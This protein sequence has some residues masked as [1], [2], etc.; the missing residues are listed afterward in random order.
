MEDSDE[1]RYTY[2]FRKMSTSIDK[3][4]LLHM[5]TCSL[6]ALDSVRQI[7]LDWDI[8]QDVLIFRN[9]FVITPP[10]STNITEKN[11]SS[12]DLFN[13]MH[14]QDKELFL[15]QL[16]QA[17]KGVDDSEFSL[18]RMELRLKDSTIGWR[19]IDISGRIVE[20]D[21]QGR[22]IRMLGYLSDINSRKQAEHKLVESDSIKREIL[23]NAL[24]CIITVNHEGAIINFNHASEKTFGYTCASILGKKFTDVVMTPAWRNEHHLELAYFFQHSEHPI[25]HR[26]VELNMMRANGTIFPVET[27]IVPIRI[28]DHPIFTCFIRDISELML[29]QAAL[30]D[31]ATRYR[32]LVEL[33]P[34][35]IFVCR[36][37]RLALTNHAA[38]QLLRA[39]HAH[40]LTDI[41]ILDFI[42]PDH[43]A[44]FLAH[45]HKLQASIPAT[46]FLE[47]QWIRQNG[48]PFFAEV[49]ATS[50]HY[51]GQLAIQ[52][53]VRDITIRKSA[54]ALQLGQN[55][56][57]NMIATGV[58][59]F[60]ILRA[61]AQFIDSQS[62][63][64]S[65]AILL[66]DC[67]GATLSNCVS[68]SLPAAYTQ[69]VNGLLV[70][71]ASGS[72][73]TAIFRAEPVVVTNIETDP[74]WSTCREIA[75]KHGL[76]A[77]SSWPIFGKNKKILG[78][79]ALYFH[80]TMAPS[81]N[82]SNLM[83]IC[84]NLAGI[85][86]DSR[87]SE[88][89]IR[90]LAHYDGLTS[91]PNRF[92]FKEYLDLALH[93]AHR[94][95]FKFAVFFLDLD[96][97]KDINDT[98]GHEAGDD[99]LRETARRLRKCLRQ[100]DKI[101]RIGGDEFYIL[102]E[103]LDH[104]HYAAEVAQKLLD[105]TVQPI[106]I[107]HHACQLSVSIGIS[108]YPDDGLNER[109]L[110]KNADHAMY[111]AKNLGKNGFQFYS[112]QAFSFAEKT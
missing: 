100:T 8:A 33:S 26:R 78:T 97:F 18:Y 68:L 21:E 80:D 5:K 83:H 53:T 95:H 112:E 90:Y 30:K 82:E 72:C 75:L 105:E 99:V 22:A 64:G 2:S 7:S 69:E 44:K 67:D 38:I 45:T 71:P 36:S 63:H 4:H 76:L 86:I 15:S 111:R 96:K 28:G 32:Q 103:Q 109:S 56:I 48:A 85:A 65:C 11:W 6:L 52:L 41:S 19:W 42:H 43:H 110:L 12:L 27:S 89:R 57:L 73:G 93:T 24:D 77:C 55:K 46:P 98:L 14:D 79:I 108:I 16:H 58:E 66:L 87:V 3:A 13:L 54:E 50:L 39:Q 9:A 49:A 20:R 35:A 61:I 29:A 104:A 1:C 23:S 94:N 92:L 34:D 62:E 17:F 51:D 106:T 31:S 40:E 101:A 59:L 37:N 102:I 60:D 107:G 81:D 10:V 47:Q 70:A 74:L 91:L 84:T 25:F 88:E